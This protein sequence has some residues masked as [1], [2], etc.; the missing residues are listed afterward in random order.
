ME[1]EI[2]FRGKLWVSLLFVEGG[3]CAG[4][5]LQGW[6]APGP[7]FF[8]WGKEDQEQWVMQEGEQEHD[9]MQEE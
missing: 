8:V 4:S 3:S 2:I 7:A 6:P 5:C 9:L 1:R